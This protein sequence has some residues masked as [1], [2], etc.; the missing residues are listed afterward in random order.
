MNLFLKYSLRSIGYDIESLRP[1]P[2]DWK[3]PNDA[4]FEDSDDEDDLSG[5]T[6]DDEDS[7]IE[8]SDSDH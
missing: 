5:T 6:S 1:L 8:F 4:S 7:C 2:R 3:A